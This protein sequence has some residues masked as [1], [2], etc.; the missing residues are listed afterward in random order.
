MVDDSTHG[1][2]LLLPLSVIF[3]EYTNPD[4]VRRWVWPLIRN[5][6]YESAATVTAV[7]GLSPP[8]NRV[9]PMPIVVLRPVPA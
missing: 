3:A 9:M 5:N 6:P 7:L 2:C 4:W 1:M 8:R